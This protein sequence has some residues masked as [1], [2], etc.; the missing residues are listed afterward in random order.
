MTGKHLTFDAS[1]DE[2]KLFMSEGEEQLEIL[3]QDILRLEQEGD[4]N[5][6]LLQEIFRAAHTLK[7]S[8]GAIGHTRLA[9]LTHAC[10]TVLDQVRHHTLPVNTILVDLMLQGLDALR[11]LLDEVVTSVESDITIDTLVVSLNELASGKTADKQTA[12]AEKAAP[13]IQAPVASATATAAG[14]NS[15]QVVCSFA[16]DCL[17]P[18][19]RALQA[20]F[21]GRTLGDVIQTDPPITAIEDGSLTMLHNM[22]LTIESDRDS[23]EFTKECLATIERIPEVKVTQIVNIAGGTDNTIVSAAAPSNSWHVDL[24]IDAG[25]LMPA[26]RALQIVLAADTIGTIEHCS[27]PRADIDDGK[28]DQYSI[29]IELEA[30]DANDLET[31]IRTAMNRI[32]EVTIVSMGHGSLAPAGKQIAASKFVEA[33]E[34][35]A[36]H[37]AIAA[38]SEQET[39]TNTVPAP[40]INTSKKTSEADTTAKQVQ[41]TP[42]TTAS[43]MIRIDVERLDAL[44]NLVGELVIDRTRLARIAARLSTQT[45]DTALVEELTETSQHLTRVSDD[46]QVEVMHSRMQPIESV[47]SKFP[48]LV[49]DLTQKLNKKIDF[50]VEGKDTELDRSVAEQIG[51]PIIHLL[52]N[53]IDHGIESE[54]ERLKS[55]KSPVGQVRLGARHEENQIVIDIEDDGH[56]IDPEKLKAKAVQRGIISTEIAARM[57][58]REAVDLIFTSGFSTAEQVSDVSGR[59]VGMDIVRTNIERLNGSISMETEVGQGT[60][61]TIRLPLTLAIIRALLITVG[62]QTYAIPL[63]SVVEALR[64]QNSQLRSINGHEAIELRGQVLPLTRLSTIFQVAT[65]EVEN[66]ESRHFVVAVRWGDRRGGLIVDSL[67]GEQ[68][69]V[70][71]SLGNMFRSAQGISGGAVLGDG[72]VAPILDIATLIK[73]IINNQQ[74]ANPTEMRTAS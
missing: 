74:Y 7:G 64:I 4:T 16:S 15:W 10:E 27:P 22:T 18:A 13:V 54:D 47:F 56:G 8:S 19:A 68:E 50:I 26:A 66:D 33:H 14:K 73:H 51:D 5:T 62:K 70:I 71:K 63:S 42:A 38:Y 24:A 35:D 45:N 53:S 40:E 48:R 21:A 61:F 44:M 28:C 3:S 6:E 17:L 41:S 65:Q 9:R 31:V 32:P 69:I 23:Q 43:R 25:C 58:H 30:A 39:S 11:V 1:P 67:I 59:G 60:R 72:Q 34:V 29:H 12:P 2:L 37:A 57:S 55:G 52:R 20:L 46:L 36:L 49:R